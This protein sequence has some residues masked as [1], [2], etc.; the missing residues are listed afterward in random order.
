MKFFRRIRL[1]VVS[2]CLCA[3]GVAPLV[4]QPSE[5]QQPPST[6]PAGTPTQPAKPPAGTP[7]PQPPAQPPRNPFETVPQVQPDPAQQPPKPIAQP[8]MEAP[9]PLSATP[10]PLA[11][12]AVEAIEFRGARRV[13]Q[14]TLKAQITTKPGDLYSDEILRRDFMILWNT[15]RFDGDRK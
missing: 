2:A 8:Q 9:K 10:Q 5:Q 7:Q 6:P 15:A 3:S 4:A 11:G 12:Q 1:V 14:D 13:P